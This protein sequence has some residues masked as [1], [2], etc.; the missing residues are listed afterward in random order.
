MPIYL[1]LHSFRPRQSILEGCNIKKRM[2]YVVY[3]SLC[4]L[5]NWERVC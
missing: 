5:G 2:K 1:F 3:R 4:G